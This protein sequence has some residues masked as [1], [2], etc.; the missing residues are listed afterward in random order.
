MDYSLAKLFE[1]LIKQNA[2]DLHL[3]AGSPPRLRKDGQVV[4]LDLPPLSPNDCL[5]LCYSVLT[6]AQ[7]KYFEQNKEIDLSFSV[8]QLA[9]FRANIFMES[10]NIA[11]AFRLVPY[12]IFSLEELNTPKVLKNSVNFQEA[13]F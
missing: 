2:S 1:A 5:D 4:S 11:G 12:K 8:K 9:R 6:E 10:G 3:A 13:W 7:K